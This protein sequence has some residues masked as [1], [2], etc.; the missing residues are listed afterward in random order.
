MEVHHGIMT[1]NNNNKNKIIIIKYRE[2]GYIFIGGLNFN[3]N[4]GDVAIVFSQFG[5]ISDL[6][7]IRDQK[8]GKSKGY[9]F[10]CYED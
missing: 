9:C 8:T 7:L 5:E 2:S 1:Y 3:M 4:E 10:L 6:L